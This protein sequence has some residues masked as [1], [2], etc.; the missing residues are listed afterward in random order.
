[1]H[2]LVRKA[3]GE[4]VGDAIDKVSMGAAI[5]LVRWFGYEARRVLSMVNE[6]DRDYEIRQWCDAIRSLGGEVSVRDWQRE[7][8]LASAS[9]AQ[10]QLQFL[11]DMHY[12]TLMKQYSGGK[13]GRPSLVFKMHPTLPANAQVQA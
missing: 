5:A 8:C 3:S 9:T 7:G 10:A 2:H 12:G 11:A 1:M 4:I 13:G 6:D